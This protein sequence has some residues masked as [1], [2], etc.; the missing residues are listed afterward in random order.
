MDI[1]SLFNA[2][3]GAVSQG[4]MWGIMAIGVFITYKIMDIADLSVDG[5]VS[6]GAAVFAV[7]LT[8]GH[9]IWAC[10][11]YATPAGMAAGLVTGI[12]HTV[13][14]IPAILAG[15]ITQFGLYSI[16]LKILGGSNMTISN[17]TYDLIESA[18]YQKGGYPFYK[19]PVF[20]F[21]VASILLI[22]ILYWFFGTER[23]AS[24]RATGSN[25][26]MSRAQG[27]NT[28]VNKVI[29]LVL[30][31]GIVAF[32]GAL[33]GQYSG[34]ANVN[35]GRGAI[36]I[37]LAAVV[38]GGAIFGKI[39]KNFALQLVGV[40]LGGV[41]YYI[42]VQLILWFPIDPNLLKFI[43]AMV[44]AVFLAFPYWKE[45]FIVKPVKI[46]VKKEVE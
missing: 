19:W 20:V 28:N 27:I 9:N 11:L 35:T 3:P 14:G 6:L 7:T 16:N 15:I 46:S 17:R 41:V 37:G 34:A 45:K 29:G 44:I 30:S 38:I 2:M 4:M 25:P 1:A 12:F 13:M 26:N 10:M 36:V 31:N 5:T 8:S 32:S 33:M 43:Q 42:I 23:G 24:I 18:M 22:M 21:A 39:F 40:V